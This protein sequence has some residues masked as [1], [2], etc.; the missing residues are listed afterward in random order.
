MIEDLK[1]CKGML[2]MAHKTIKEQ[3]DRI[4]MLNNELDFKDKKITEL[5]VIIKYLEG[6]INECN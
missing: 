5:N 2:G 4:T 6:K 1:E 3:I